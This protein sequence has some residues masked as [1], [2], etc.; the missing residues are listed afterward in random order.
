M[1]DE[2]DRPM[3]APTVT[4]SGNELAGR[5]ALVTG[6]TAGI[7][8]AAARA[9]AAAGATVTISARDAAHG[10]KVAVELGERVR[11]LA[12][13]M[14]DR[15]AV[16]DLAR[17]CEVDIL[18][19]NA[20]SFPG[21][22]TLDQDAASFD[23]TFA[24]N[25]RGTY[26]LVAAVVPAMI[27]RGGGAIVNVTSMVATKGV[28][29]ASVYSASKAAV[30]SLTRVWAAEFGPHGIRVNN[31]APGPTATEGVAAQWGEVNEELGRALPMGR[32]AHPREIAEAVL[33][34]ASPRASFITGTTLHVDG[35]GT[36]I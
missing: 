36:A 18:V 26:F 16:D 14:S 4:M 33:F 11:F 23:T 9:L 12:A 6:G 7:G 5:T 25:V 35:G 28:P 19:N 22:P 21:A 20:A 10:E 13:D 2:Y 15:D 8:L 34:L 17:H 1:T 3:W 27:R 32:T 29:G 24:T 30:E 31:V